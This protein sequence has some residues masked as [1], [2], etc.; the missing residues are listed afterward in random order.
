[1]VPKAQATVIATFGR[2]ALARD[3]E[4]AKW[5]VF[6]RGKKLELAVGDRVALEPSAEGQAWVSAI[7]ARKNLLYRS[8]EHKMK[9]FAA[10]L[11]WVVLVV[12]P[13]PPLSPELVLRT[14][15]ASKAAGLPLILLLNK[16]DLLTD[17]DETLQR[18]TQLLPSFPEDR[19]LIMKLSVKHNPEQAQRILADIFDQKTSLI[20][21][22]SGMGKSTLINLM[23]PGATVATAEISTALNTGKHTTT[24][25]QMHDLPKGGALIDSPGFQAFGLAHIK[26]DKLEEVFDFILQH[27]EGCR[28]YNCKHVS[29]PGCGVLR[30]QTEGRIRP[31][32]LSF[33]HALRQEAREAKRF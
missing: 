6:T 32:W 16:S 23:V 5:Q 17:N 1:M 20:L 10:N 24:H 22:Q 29:E 7:E 18:L 33:Y 28:F 4:G 15:V 30:A 8:D 25:T 14:W 11:D 26:Q 19:P 27:R 2:H 31:E 3:D 9:V 13:S 21:G 12:A